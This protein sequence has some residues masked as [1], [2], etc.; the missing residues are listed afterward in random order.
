MVNHN[1]VLK[2]NTA[3][4]PAAPL[5][6]PITAAQTD[7]NCSFGQ[8]TGS[9][10]LFNVNVVNTDT[11]TWYGQ[12]DPNNDL[13]I[14]YVTHIDYEEGTNLFGNTDLTPATVGASIVGTVQNAGTASLQEQYIIKFTVY[15]NGS[16]TPWGYY[17]IDPV[18]TMSPSNR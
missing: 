8:T 10:E 7:A 11:V 4:I 15:K 6:Q 13:D 1:I 16:S 18:I 3:S 14:V 12:P 2:V 9:N 17:E 5:N